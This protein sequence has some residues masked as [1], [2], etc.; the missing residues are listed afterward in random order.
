MGGVHKKRCLDTIYTYYL[1]MCH[2]SVVH[3][4]LHVKGKFQRHILMLLCTCQK[5]EHENMF[6]A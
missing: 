5:V 1:Y 4:R 6:K 2:K 3:L